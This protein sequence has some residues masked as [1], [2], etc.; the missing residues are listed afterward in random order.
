M[1]YET[2]FIDIVNVRPL[3]GD[4]SS[5]IWQ[6]R[7]RSDW[8]G[9]C[10]QLYSNG[11][12]IAVTDDPA[13]RILLAQTNSVV[14]ALTVVAC[15]PGQRQL[16]AGGLL[17]LVELAEP[18]LRR[19]RVAAEPHW[20]AGDVLRV[21]TEAGTLLAERIIGRADLA[22]WG[23]GDDLLG[24]GGFGWDG[25]RAAGHALGEFGRGA[26]GFGGH[27]FEIDLAASP[28]R[29]ELLLTFHRG[30]QSSEPRGLGTFVFTPPPDPP[31][32]LRVLGHN[33]Q[34]DQLIFQINGV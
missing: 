30:R 20:R 31:G 9:Y 29:H 28:G 13:E 1:T 34:T 22:P 16:G 24:L 33:E 3:A 10:H 12:L 15:R 2:D 14:G 32:E 27:S 18:W 11:R 4:P 8:D 26:F 6:I 21:T 7:F 23:F 5:R 17:G 25:A 19:V